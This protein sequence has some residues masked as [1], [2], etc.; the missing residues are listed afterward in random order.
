MTTAVTIMPRAV[1]IAPPGG[2]PDFDQF[3]RANSFRGGRSIGGGRRD[4]GFSGGRGFGSNGR[5]RRWGFA[6]F[7]T[8]LR[9]GI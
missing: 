2:T 1:L 5:Y 8:R 7:R 6:R 4:R 9:A 3:G